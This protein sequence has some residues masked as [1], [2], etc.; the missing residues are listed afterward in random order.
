[1]PAI[2]QGIGVDRNEQLAPLLADK[3]QSGFQLLVGK[4]QTG[5]V[6]G[7]GIVTKTRV[8]SIGTLPHRCL[9]GRQ[10]AC[11][12]DQLHGN[13]LC[14]ISAGE[15]APG[16]RKGHGARSRRSF[17]G[18]GG[19]APARPGG[20][21][22]SNAPAARPPIELVLDVPGVQTYPRDSVLALGG[23]EHQL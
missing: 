6:T 8:D 7:V 18:P 20:L 1:R 14:S 17:N 15:S 16:G 19:S 2:G 5:E 11:G 22:E 4:V 3:L 12:T 21:A 13:S 23:E 9:E 10:T